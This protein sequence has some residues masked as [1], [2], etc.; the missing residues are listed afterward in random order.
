MFWQLINRFGEGNDNPLQYSC[1]ENHMYRGAWQV[2]VHRVA[3]SDT[4]EV[5][6]HTNIICITGYVSPCVRLTCLMALKLWRKLSRDCDNS[7]LNFALS[8]YLIVHINYLMEES[9]VMM[10]EKVCTVSGC[11]GKVTVFSIMSSFKPF[12]MWFLS[13]KLN[14]HKS[15]PW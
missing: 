8:Y 12:Q 1:L 6:K 15:I 13:W 2:L 4:N 5:K 3:G 14:H 11:L 7:E 9:A 10:D